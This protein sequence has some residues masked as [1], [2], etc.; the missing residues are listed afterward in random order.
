MFGWL[1]FV[2]FS[3]ASLYGSKGGNEQVSLLPAD[4]DSSAPSHLLL[5]LFGET[6]FALKNWGWI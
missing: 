1:F 2:G 4:T 6:G 5:T 3:Q